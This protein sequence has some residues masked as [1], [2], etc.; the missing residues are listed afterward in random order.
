M[1]TLQADQ[2]FFSQLEEAF[3][4]SNLEFARAYYLFATAKLSEKYN[5][6][7]I[8]QRYPLLTE[9]ETFHKIK[10]LYDA[11]ASNEELKRLFTS[12]LGT[13]IGNQLCA[14]S[15]EIENLKNQLKIPVAG[16]GIRDGEGR[17]IE[18]LLYEDVAEWLKKLEDKPTREALYQRMSEGHGK[19]VAP[20]FIQYLEREIALFQELGY[21][22]LVRFYSQTS[23]HDL[24]KLGEKGKYLVEQ[25]E[26]LYRDRVAA[27][28][29]KRTGE[30][31]SQAVRAD[32][33][34]VFHG[35]DPE[36]ASIDKRFPKENLVPLA[37]KTFDGLGLAF[38]QVAHIVDY[39]SMADYD[40]EV[41]H[42]PK[43]EAPK[44]L[45]DIAHRPGKRS[46]ALPVREA[47][48]RPG[49][50]LGLLP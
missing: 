9:E 18:E 6:E 14:L 3:R 37:Q 30:D 4:Q 7:E 22:D 29:R 26:S 40:T 15:D 32:I 28:Y 11:D 48:R 19:T 31:F 23:G 5:S 41:V 34:Y 44:I 42:N 24:P 45:L 16:L 43:P 13:Y 27:Q 50:L 1:T 2:T 8:Y 38:S 39:P 35:K 12:V 49:R 21:G 36:M 47:G 46:R 10:A 25:T 20:K 33:L 17:E